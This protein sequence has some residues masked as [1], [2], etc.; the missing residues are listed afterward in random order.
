M[1]SEIVD[2]QYQLNVRDSK[3]IVLFLVELEK[4]MF[5]SEEEM[6]VYALNKMITP[7]VYT[8]IEKF[9]G[10]LNSLIPVVEE[11]VEV[12]GKEE[13]FFNLME[14]KSAVVV[15]GESLTGKTTFIRN[16][17]QLRNQQEIHYIT[18]ESLEIWEIVGSHDNRIQGLLSNIPREAWIVFDGPLS[19]VEPIYSQMQRDYISLEKGETIL[20]KNWKVI[21]E[22]DT[23]SNLP[24]TLIG[25]VGLL[26]LNDNLTFEDII[27]KQ[28]LKITN[29]DI[30]AWLLKILESQLNTSFRKIM[31]SR[32]SFAL[33][34]P[35]NDT[36]LLLSCCSNLITIC[37]SFTH[38]LKEKDTKEVKKVV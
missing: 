13:I 7:R 6:L 36:S 27:A 32:K 15:Y 21:F 30:P 29:P 12:V 38:H 10:F 37:N 35:T 4:E 14:I 5:K 26:N 31:N 18:V 2:A 24:P 17:N 23:L 8:N 19:S 34:Y 20:N 11:T 9:K 1:N 22:A 28:L 16:M 33:I 25:K 3:Q